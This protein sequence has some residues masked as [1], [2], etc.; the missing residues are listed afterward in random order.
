MKSVGAFIAV[1]YTLAIALSLLIGW[2]GGHSSPL[3]ALGYLSMLLPAFSVLIVRERPRVKWERLPMP[4][5]PLALFLIPAVMHA[6][7]LPLMSARGVLRWKQASVGGV[8]ANAVIGLMIV[9]VLAFFEEIGWRAWLLPRLADRFD[10]RLAVVLTSAIWAVWHLPF[11]LSGILYIEGVNPT[12]LIPVQVLGTFAA[13]LILG[14]LWLRTE[15]IW[16]VSIAHGSLNNWGQ[17]AFKYLQD[18][19][20]PDRDLLVLAA[21]SAALLA[22]GAALL[23]VFAPRRRHSEF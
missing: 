17:F 19:G 10:A 8:I 1:A 3:I 16:L 7:M 6:V 11:L 15:S 9:A 14:W 4:Y 18:T 2:T 21:G 12:R 5:L 20:T 13:G 22:V 23:M